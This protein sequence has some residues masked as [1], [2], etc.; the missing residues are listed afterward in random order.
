MDNKNFSSYLKIDKVKINDSFWNEITEL[1]R[2]EVIT[3]QYNALQD[4]IENAEKSYC[5]EN[6][7]KAGKIKKAFDS[8]TSVPTYPVDKWQYTDNNC[9]KNAFHGWVF[10]DSDVY[11][12]I[13][14]AAYSLQNHH[15]EDLK[16]KA[17]EFIDIICNAQLDNGYLDTLY[18]INDRSKI[19]T[20]LKDYH[21]LY[22]F[23][24][25]AEAAVA[26]YN[27]T[28]EKKLLDSACRFA[29]LICNTFNK[30]GKHGY[31]GHEI[32][33]MALVKLYKTTKCKQYLETA[34]FFIE[35]RGKKPYYFDK[36]HGIETVGDNYHYNQAHIQPKFQTEAVGHAVRGVYLYSA[37]A[38]LAKENN[39]EELYS[40]CNKIWNNIVNQKLYI[41]GG[42]GATVD[43][44][45][46]SFDYDLPNDLAYSETCASIGLIFFAKRMSEIENKSEYAEIIERALYNCVLSAMA[47]DG[48]A[49]FYVNPLEVLPEASHKDS[50]KAH[51]KAVRQKWFSCACCPPNLARLLSSIN[52][53]IYSE[54]DNTIFINQFIESTAKCKKCKLD[55]SSDILNS[56]KINI[57]ITDIQENFTLA[58]RLPEYIGDYY[59]NTEHAL[60]NGYMYFNINCNCEIKIE[61]EIK[62]MLIKCSNRVRANLGKVAVCRGPIVYALEEMDNS[63]NLHMLTIDAKSKLIYNESDKTITAV[64]YREKPDDKLYNKYKEPEKEKIELTFIPYYK[65]GNRGENEMSVYIRLEK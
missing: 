65:W 9:D 4:K 30:N 42:I 62:P 10:Q 2:N 32:A 13:E 27:C 44:E 37:M 16:K 53:Y 29:D 21:E 26:Y 58:V 54:N 63:N 56:G 25:L 48:K 33:E 35:E 18:I 1:V 46:F 39:N 57:K 6:F 52:E 64:G 8:G 38:D 28:G 43:G 12:W 19:F 36:E 31:P 40:A 24:H 34:E 3:Y 22:C 20:N 51:I 55:L 45:S 5:I 17:D 23:G 47:E 49:F 15:N 41:T 59:S 61:F 11:K 60:K 7:I 50:R 14:A